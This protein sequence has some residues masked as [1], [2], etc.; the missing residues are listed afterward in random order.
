M[1]ERRN[2]LS[3]IGGDSNKYHTCYITSYSFDFMF[4]EQRILPKLRRA[5]MVNINVFV[6]ASMFEKQMA[7]LDGNFV[8]KQSYSI[9]PIRINGAFHPK[10]LMCLG[11]NN[12]M[13]A[14]GSGNLTHSGLSGNDEVWGAFH[15]YKSEGKAAPLFSQTYEYLLKLK[16]FSYGYNLKKWSWVMPN[17]KWLKDIENPSEQVINEKGEEVHLIGS[18]QDSSIYSELKSKLP[19]N[20]P[21]RI[22][23]ISPYFN[24]DGRFLKQLL[25][26]YQPDRMDVIIDGRFGTVPYLMENDSRIQFHQWHELKKDETKI[27]PRLHAKM[28]QFEYADSTYFFTGSSNA[29]E[30]AFG[31]TN[32]PS[33]NAEMNI[34]IHSA[35]VKNYLEEMEILIPDKGLDDISKVKTSPIEFESSSKYEKKCHINQVDKDLELISIY[36]EDDSR[37]PENFNICIELIDKPKPSLYSHKGPVSGKIE[38]KISEVDAIRGFRLF[39]ADT[40]G[41]RISNYQRLQDLSR[42]ERTNPDSKAKRLLD[43][44]SKEELH[45]D[46][47]ITLLEFANFDKAVSASDSS[48]GFAPAKN[49]PDKQEVEKNYETLGEE[50]FNKKQS[51]IEEYHRSAS[52][53]LGL[54][55]NFLNDMVFAVPQKENLSDDPEAAALE[56]GD[57]GIDND[58]DNGNPERIVLSFHDGQK[59]H[60]KLHNTLNNISL[61]LSWK[62]SEILKKLIKYLEV[63]TEVGIEDIKSLLVG[64]HLLL[65]KGSKAYIEERV[66]LIVQYKDI[67][68]LDFFE[69]KNKRLRLERLEKQQEGHKNVAYSADGNLIDDVDENLITVEGV[70]LLYC[71]QTPSMEISHQYFMG[72]PVLH[73][74]KQINTTIKG[75]L[76]NVV[77]PSLLSILNGQAKLKEDDK[78]K[79]ESFK[80]RLLLRVLALSSM[81]Y[82]SRNEEILLKLLILNSIYILSTKEQIETIE[83]DMN[84]LM[85]KLEVKIVSNKTET[86]VKRYI[87]EYINWI[88]VFDN[89]R[90]KLIEILTLKNIEN[91]IFKSKIGFAVIQTLGS[92]SLN[93]MTPLGAYNTESNSYEIRNF[94]SGN[95]VILFK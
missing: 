3:L 1:I 50:E 59:I 34:L 29:T 85:S 88:S 18:F 36:V 43:I 10:I 63:S 91:I 56:A 42:I 82:W 15:T 33:K 40:N 6:D 20:K 65:I 17:S 5:G 27:S 89:D 68:S 46:D 14:I 2:I 80:Y 44:I 77:A 84:S 76:I 86:T 23:I 30:E 57:E 22:S 49:E 12:G 93:L 8:Y 13:L 69:K 81:V 21:Q 25:E 55:E 90:S 54:L 9:T 52:T 70:K 95:K 60:R 39:I 75:Y 72:G 38:L 16:S 32:E 41:Q 53:N 67:D 61:A 74:S 26:E 94:K 37:L 87:S 35:E 73:T 45:D 79:Y 64:A 62:H 11:K 58:D 28:I 78:T 51:E 19:T 83:D 47:L 31:N 92:N 66:K 24:K 7:Q 48:R 4:F 71:D